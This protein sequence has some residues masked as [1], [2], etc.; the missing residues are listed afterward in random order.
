MAINTGIIHEKN[1]FYKK[2]EGLK[3][4]LDYFIYDNNTIEFYHTYVPEPLRGRGLAMEIIQEGLDYAVANNYR[5]IPSCSA[6]R[7]FM[8]R[9]PEYRIKNI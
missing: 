3:C 4:E 2:V 1:S 5:I 6:V 7:K 8:D 9:H